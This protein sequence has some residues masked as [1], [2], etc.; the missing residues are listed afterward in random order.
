MSRLDS[1]IRRMTAQRDVLNHICERVKE[2][3]GPVLELGLG[4]GR[5]FD[6]LRA[7]FPGR[8]IIA[9]DRAVGSHKTSTPEPEN[10]VVGEIRIPLAVLERGHYSIPASE[11]ESR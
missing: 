1:F 8:K 6:H 9:F 11:E 4:N 10:L 2:L 7:H 5:T 3:D